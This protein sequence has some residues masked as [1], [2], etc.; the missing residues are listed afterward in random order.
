M[1]ER[2]PSR[3]IR[4]GTQ[5]K[6]F[7]PSC[8]SKNPFHLF[9]FVFIIVALERNPPKSVYRFRLRRLWLT[10]PIAEPFYCDFVCEVRRKRKRKILC[11][12]A[13]SSQLETK[14]LLAD[15]AFVKTKARCGRPN[16]SVASCGNNTQY[17]GVSCIWDA[18]RTRPMGPT[19]RNAFLVWT[20]YLIEEMGQA[21]PA[22]TVSVVCKTVGSFV[23]C[24][25]WISFRRVLITKW[26]TF[27]SFS[28]LCMVCSM[29]FSGSQRGNRIFN[30]IRCCACVLS[31]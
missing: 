19:M 12:R 8:T 28:A 30:D 4:T 26:A 14:E 21:R 22:T 3:H 11:T 13:I 2:F 20:V 15:K 25:L 6:V 24:W 31:S 7:A 16:V 10:N 1:W 5:F 9:V 23:R 18:G 27:S 29:S 17:T